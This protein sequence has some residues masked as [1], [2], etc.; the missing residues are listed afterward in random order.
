[1]MANSLPAVIALVQMGVLEFHPWGSSARKLGF[2]D[3]VIFDID[4]DD[5]LRGARSPRAARLVKSLV[6]EIGLRGFPEDDR[7]QR[8]AR[9]RAGQADPAVGCRQGVHPERRGTPRNNIPGP[10]HRD[11]VQIRSPRQDLPRLSA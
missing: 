10:L 4:P 1:M 8:P 5:D 3:R 7:W 2:P 6:E 11:D 9:R